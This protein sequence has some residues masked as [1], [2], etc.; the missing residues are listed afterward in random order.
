MKKEIILKPVKASEKLFKDFEK[1][2]LIKLFRPTLKTISTKTKTGAVSRL[3]SSRKIFGTHSLMCVGKRTTDIRL[4]YHD[5][6]EDLILLNPLGMKFKKLY[7][8]VSA[9]KKTQFL[10]KFLSGLLSPKD[11]TAVELEFNDPALS[12]FTVL[13]GTVHCEITDASKKQHPIF[14]VSEPSRLKDNKLSAF[15]YDIRISPEKT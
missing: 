11:L 2:K 4:S 10:K 6:N 14:F 8:I 13:K 3:Y 9:L 7:F 1:K 12:F 15:L 5:D